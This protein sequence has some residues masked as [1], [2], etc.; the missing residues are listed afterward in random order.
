MTELKRCKQCDV[1]LAMHS[2]WELHD[3]VRKAEWQREEV[4]KRLLEHS[5]R[6]ILESQLT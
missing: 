5:E 4:I 3:C 1:P 2:I 6:Q